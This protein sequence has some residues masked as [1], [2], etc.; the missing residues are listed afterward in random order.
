[1]SSTVMRTWVHSLVVPMVAAINGHAFAGGWILG[2]GCDYR[3]MASGRC[4]GSMNEVSL[5]SLSSPPILSI[6]GIGSYRV[7][8][9]ACHH[10]ISSF[11]IS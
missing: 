7:R 9:P 10:G 8:F 6:W 2:A 5:N 11:Q 3:I 4:W 1:M